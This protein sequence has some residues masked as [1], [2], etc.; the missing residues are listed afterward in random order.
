M[1]SLINLITNCR[2]NNKT[3]NSREVD[4]DQTPNK[5]KCIVV[6]NAKIMNMEEGHVFVLFQLTKE[7]FNLVKMVARLVIVEVVPKKIAK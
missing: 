2:K 5:N 3:L 1:K 4:P 6:I 7:K